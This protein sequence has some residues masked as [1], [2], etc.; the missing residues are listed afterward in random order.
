M[1]AQH[2]K[3][4]VK[5]NKNDAADAVSRMPEGI[6]R[7]IHASG[8]FGPPELSNIVGA[9]GYRKNPKN[10]GLGLER[11]RSRRWAGFCRLV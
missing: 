8:L 7:A 2:V 11:E 1:P 9:S 10:G 4:Y 5:R 3:A 6:D